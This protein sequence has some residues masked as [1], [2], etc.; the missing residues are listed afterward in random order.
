MTD[1]KKK[2]LKS[3]DD[4][5]DIITELSDNIFDHPET[6][7]TEKIS[8][9]LQIDV[10]KKLG[11]TVTE[12]LAGIPTAF[13]G[14][15]GNGK[16]VIGILGEF[17]AL[18]GLSQEPGCAKQKAIVEGGNGHGCGHNLLG[19]ASIAAAYAVKKYIDENGC[20]GTVIYYGCPAEEGGS[21]KGFMVR[22]GVF[23]EL[24]CAVTWHP[25]DTNS[26]SPGSSLANIV[27]R[28]HFS[29][30]SAHAAGAPHLG[31][32]ALD[33]VTL[34]N[35]GVQFLREHVIQEARIHYAVTNTGGISPNVVQAEAEVLYMIRAPK[36]NQVNEIYAR[37]NDI[38]KGAALMTGTKMKSTFVKATSD[39]QPNRVLAELLQKN[40]EENT[41]PK[42][43][44]EELAFA[45]E[46]RKTFPVT[47]TS[48]KRYLS[49]L[50]EETAA[51]LRK[52][53][54]DAICD[55]VLPLINDETAMP[56]STDV[57]D[58]SQVCPTAQISAA[59][60]VLDTPGHSWQLT[61]Q[62]KSS[63]AHKSELY[64][65]K[66]MAGTVIDLFN[67]AALVKA[68]KDEY[69]RRRDG[70]PFVSPIPKKTKPP[71]PGK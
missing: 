20:S 19:S 58:V 4:I 3:I 51:K 25:G 65:G 35:T 48:M 71:V 27:V 64:A 44:K 54:D 56:G 9:Q 7:Y 28:Y 69:D 10:L 46:L 68:A 45:E 13:S 38:A 42:A 43:T 5:A 33:A 31:R 32:S 29:G 52:H 2:A 17:D 21:G 61:A 16:P 67:D 8:A 18:S 34:M 53:L 23:D 50:P 66:V 41:P 63:R 55:Y 47:G 59:T 60:Q 49:R 15:Y 40:L 37:V 70:V 36:I 14:R 22:D 12:K 62:G 24:D 30:V 39:L 11:F 6:G 1:S 26:V 57:G